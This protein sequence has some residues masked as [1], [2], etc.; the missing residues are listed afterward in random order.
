[1]TAVY[2]ECFILIYVFEFLNFCSVLF[3]MSV[4]NHEEIR[5]QQ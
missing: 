5:E 1:L 4:G 2:V 3:L